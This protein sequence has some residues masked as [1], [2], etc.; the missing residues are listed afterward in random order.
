M[1]AS[2]VDDK[3]T[4]G[5]FLYFLKRI[6]VYVCVYL[7]WVSHQQ[8]LR[9]S[10]SVIM[11]SYPPTYDVTYLQYIFAFHSFIIASHFLWLL[12]GLS[13]M[14]ITKLIQHRICLSEHLLRN[15]RES[16][17]IYKI[18]HTH[19]TPLQ[20]S[21]VISLIAHAPSTALARRSRISNL[22]YQLERTLLNIIALYNILFDILRLI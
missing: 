16:W 15:K 2:D 5:I 6:K 3:K 12:V 7:T 13:P 19:I 9:M 20:F 17:L 8:T 22:I 14:F 10:I 11:N 4:I 21:C 1:K 18:L